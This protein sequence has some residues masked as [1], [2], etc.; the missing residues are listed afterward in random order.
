MNLR[1][2]LKWLLI[3]FLAWAGFTLAND[4]IIRDLRIKYSEKRVR[5][6]IV[7]NYNEHKSDFKNLIKFTKD[8]KPIREIEFRKNGEFFSLITSDSF[9]YEG[10][11][12][13]LKTVDYEDLPKTDYHIGE[14]RQAMI[15]I[16][17][18]ILK[19]YNW[20]WEFEGDSNNSEYLNFLDLIQM[21]K[22]QLDSLRI[23]VENLNCEA[24]TIH[25]DNSIALRYDG[26][27]M[28]QYEYLINK[29]ETRIPEDYIQIEREIYF[30]ENRS[31]LFCGWMIY[32]K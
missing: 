2:T 26:F 32:G 19:T 12:F 14:N 28:C 17:G 16:N 24:I 23:L 15:N 10:L 6:N 5:K 21:T 3:I 30:G 4:F 13:P 22:E 27:S 20:S 8:L 11:N 29:E 7:H 18:T 9:D 25:N 1:K 31:E